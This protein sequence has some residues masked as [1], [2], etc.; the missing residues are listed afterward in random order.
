MISSSDGAG[1][2]DRSPRSRGGQ[3]AS[4]QTCGRAARRP[5][6]RSSTHTR[7]HGYNHGA[8]PSCDPFTRCF[9]VTQRGR[10]G[11]G[12]RRRAPEGPWNNGTLATLSVPSREYSH[13]APRNLRA[14]LFARPALY[15]AVR[16]ARLPNEGRSI[17]IIS[18]VRAAREVAPRRGSSRRPTL[19]RRRPFCYGSAWRGRRLP[20]LFFCG[21][22]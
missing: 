3:S 19:H 13:P 12:E 22:R 8:I 4:V 7:H 16:S 5:E 2:R 14:A 11:A 1:Q 21:G 17:R 18:I 15:S 6:S 20:T 9:A 10:L